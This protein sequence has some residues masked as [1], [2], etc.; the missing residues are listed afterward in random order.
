MSDTL[1]GFTPRKGPCTTNFENQYQRT[2]TISADF[3]AYAKEYFVTNYGR[4]V[5]VVAVRS[6]SV[7]LVRQ[8]RLLIDGLSWEIPGGG[9]NRDETPE[10]AAMREC[11]EEAGIRCKSLVPLISYHPS[12][13][14]W[15][16]Y[17]YVYSS[18]NF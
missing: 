5:G 13:D 8:Y 9:V 3:G 18:P 12:V 2:Y 16:N 10:A 15:K 17:T 4:R 7:L 11:Q 6:G 1:Y 14:V